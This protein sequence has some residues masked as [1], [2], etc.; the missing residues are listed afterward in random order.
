MAHRLLDCVAC[1]LPS[2]IARIECRELARGCGRRKVGPVLRDLDER[3]KDRG[4]AA[5]GHHARSVYHAAPTRARGG[6]QCSCGTARAS[7]DSTRAIHFAMKWIRRTHTRTFHTH[8]DARP[9]PAPTPPTNPSWPVLRWL[10]HAL[11][12]P[13][14]RESVP[15][16]TLHFRGET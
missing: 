9:A 4:P 7:R 3:C 5:A 16:G 6:A 1:T 14:A 12:A 11:G 8:A 10:S 2:V 15:R 13:R